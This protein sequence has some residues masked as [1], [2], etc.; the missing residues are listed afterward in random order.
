MVPALREDS[1][2][3][4]ESKYRPLP[5]QSPDPLLGPH[6]GQHGAGTRVG[7]KSIV[8]RRQEKRKS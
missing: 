4:G 6:T 1:Q 2:E 3:E 5:P 7:K 8:G